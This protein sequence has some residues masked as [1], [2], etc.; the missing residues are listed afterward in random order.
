[1]CVSSD[2]CLT[3][4]GKIVAQTCVKPDALDCYKQPKNY[5]ADDTGGAGVIGHCVTT[6]GTGITVPS[7]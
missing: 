1:M 4:G 2:D 5:M 7:H 3:Y 6:T